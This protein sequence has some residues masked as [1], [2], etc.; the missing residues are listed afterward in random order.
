MSK[1]IYITHY[2]LPGYLLWLQKDK[3]ITN[4]A[5][6]TPVQHNAYLK[7]YYRHLED[8]EIDSDNNE[9]REKFGR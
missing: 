3:A 9:Y 6:L 7:E 2:A 1:S 5:E 4:A 8:T